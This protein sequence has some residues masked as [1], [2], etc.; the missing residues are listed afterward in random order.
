M[1]D[2]DATHTY[3]LERDDID[4]LCGRRDGLTPA[5]AV[6]ARLRDHGYE[7][8]AV[9]GRRRVAVWQT[10]ADD[11]EVLATF[12]ADRDGDDEPPELVEVVKRAAPKPLRCG[13]RLRPAGGDPRIG[14]AVQVALTLAPECESPEHW[15]WL[16]DRMLRALLSEAEHKA[17]T[18]PRDWPSGE[19]PGGR[20]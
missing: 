12:Q 15:R 11:G 6:A 9:V 14:G 18:K 19:A 8:T 20:T 10:D 7:H 16:V 17:L 5:E 3:K 4:L 2:G 1:S 13:E